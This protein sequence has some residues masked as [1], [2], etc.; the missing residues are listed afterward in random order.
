V[1][2]VRLEI[3]TV[4]ATIAYATGAG[5]QPLDRAWEVEVHGGGMWLNSP[6]RGD[7]ALPPPSAILSV[8]AP[9]LNS[10][11][12]VSSWY[13][14]DGSQ[15]LNQA[16][17]RLGVS[18]VPLDDALRSPFVNPATGGSLGTRIGRRMSRRFAVEFSVDL[19]LAEASLSTESSTAIEVS[20]VTY[21]NLWNAALPRSAPIT[22]LT[23]S[24]D[25]T[26]QQT[27]G[28]PL[29][30]TGT[31]LVTVFPRGRMEPYLAVGGGV[32]SSLGD[33]PSAHIEGAYG[34]TIPAPSL[35]FE[36]PPIVVSDRDMV[37]IRSVME[38]RG[39]FV[40]G[41]GFRYQYGRRTGLRLDVRDHMFTDARRTQLDVAPATQPGGLAFVVAG[42]PA[43]T[44]SQASGSSFVIRPT[45]SGP[46][47][48]AFET[49]KS[50]GLVNHLN[51]SAGL[52]WRF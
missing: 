21:A 10:A 51:F 31:L 45:L 18:V 25:A 30:G 5:A 42:P 33:G 37:D 44:F 2:R 1:A 32:V 35:P 26:V 39:V 6:S 52:Y 24:S 41:A 12:I 43:L 17:A 47:M 15:Q 49:F 16:L 46:A 8:P 7:S 20:R 34:F 50:T 3:L 13:F 19:G 23:V 48:A 27:G 14:G 9:S 4:L 22:G 36:I 40:F 28:R 29:V 11:R 38:T